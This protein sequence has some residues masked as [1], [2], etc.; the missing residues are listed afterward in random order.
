MLC[1]APS[2]V[3]GS[4][5]FFR[6]LLLLLLL[7]SLLVAAALESAVCYASRARLTAVPSRQTYEQIL[8]KYLSL[9]YVRV[10]VSETI[11]HSN[12]RGVPIRIEAVRAG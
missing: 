2:P 5:N 8:I 3:T 12:N 9:L 4:A 6:G 10:D 7:A 11:K 1:G